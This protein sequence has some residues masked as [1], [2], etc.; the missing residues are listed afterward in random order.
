MVEVGIIG[1]GSWGLCTLERVVEAARRTPSAFVSVHVVE[2]AR[3]GGGLYSQTCP[4][5]LVLNT[6][7]GQHSMYP[8]P[9]EVATGRLGKGFYEWVTERGY[10]WQ[11]YE[12]RISDSGTPISP[13]DFL[14]RRVMG[15]YLEWFYRTLLS[16]LPDNVTV[17]HHRKRAVDIEGTPGGR[18]LVY[19]EDGARLELDH[20]VLTLG[21]VQNAPIDNELARM[22]TSAYPV[23]RYLGSVSP[24]EKI[25]IEGMGLVALDVI[26]A[27]TIGLGGHYTTEEGG[28]LRYH[29]S[30]REPD[31]YLFSRSGYPYCA[32]SI[33]TADP[34]GGYK[35][36][37]CTAEAVARLRQAAPGQPARPLDA[38]HELL[39]LVFAEMELR[40]YSHSAQLDRGVT[41]GEEVREDL[42]AAWKRGDFA[43]RCSYYAERFGRFNAAEHFFVGEGST[44]L[45]A[46]EYEAQVYSVVEADVSEALVQGGASPVKA[47][48]ETLRAMRDVIR[49]AV[50][51]KGLTLASYR[52][53][54]GGLQSRLARPAAGPP[55]F[56][57]QQLL[58]LIDAEIV[59]IPFG[60]APQIRPIRRGRF[61]VRSTRLDR[62]FEMLLD[63]LV[64]AH[65]ETPSIGRSTSPL[66]SNLARRGRARPLTLEGTPVGSIDLTPDFHPLN[67]SGVEQRL[68]AFGLP[69]EGARYFTFYIPSPK[70][71]VRAFVD[72]EI[73]ANEMVG[74]AK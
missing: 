36:A 57:S 22:A 54:Q 61:L 71:R 32:K 7:C 63:R 16:E 27:L 45:D 17:T 28:K 14:P 56:R 44:F 43:E 33:G 23:E 29:P 11:G 48:F 2:P 25:A 49:S 35:P 51:F 64:R 30:G 24:D 58:A 74:V 12:C 6:P 10:R 67:A 46:K 47:A 3:P 62:P 8:Y 19:L 38:R 1:L 55:V 69:T 5:Y 66:L 40:Y 4:D 37:I 18:E 60:P 13:H 20:V 68:W 65:V 39:P 15:E 52:D 26:T 41:A 73:C 34:V 59:R 9:D 70:S 72:A 21:N 31:L 53:F 42:V 50:E